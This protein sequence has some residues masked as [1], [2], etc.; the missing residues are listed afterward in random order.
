MPAP[1]TGLFELAILFFFFLFPPFSDSSGPQ[2]LICAS[3]LSLKCFTSDNPAILH[4]AIRCEHFLRCR[5]SRVVVIIPTCRGYRTHH[6][7]T[8]F[9]TVLLASSGSPSWLQRGRCTDPHPMPKHPWVW[10]W[11]PCCPIFPAT[12]GSHASVLIVPSS[13]PGKTGRLSQQPYPT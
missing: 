10:H 11:T 3:K 4:F 13:S 9:W 5:A 7:V 1:Q 12:M 6:W 8:E 2:L